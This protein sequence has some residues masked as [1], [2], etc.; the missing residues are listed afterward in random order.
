MTAE[1]KTHMTAPMQ[2]RI[3]SVLIWIGV[4][5]WLPFLLLRIIGQT[6]SVI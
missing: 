6:P 3:G 5:I 1:E 2:Y 4:L